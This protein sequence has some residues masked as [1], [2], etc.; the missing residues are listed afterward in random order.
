MA[1]AK[2]HH[3]KGSKLPVA[4]VMDIVSRHSRL[5]LELPAAGQAAFHRE[6][7]ENGAGRAFELQEDILRYTSAAQL[8]KARLSADLL[9]EGLLNRVSS[10]RFAAEDFAAI[11][12]YVGA[13]DLQTSVARRRTAALK[14]PSVPPAEVLDALELCPTYAAPKTEWALPEW[15]KRFCWHRDALVERGVVFATSWEDGSEAFYFLFAT[16][17]PLSPTQKPLSPH[18]QPL[19]LKDLPTPC[20]EGAS[21]EEC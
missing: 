7:L 21:V 8:D 2:E 11:Q 12:F 20:L 10:T 5:F 17:K 14:A 9:E 13:V 18:F 19:L 6:A 16:Q 1:R 4:V 15:L 3:P